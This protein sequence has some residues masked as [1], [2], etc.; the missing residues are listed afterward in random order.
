MPRAQ[1]RCTT[2]RCKMYS[3]R[4]VRECLRHVN[5]L[6]DSGMPSRRRART[7]SHF[8]RGALATARAQGLPNDLDMRAREARV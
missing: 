7:L 2:M 6:K 5:L 4:S 8:T 3:G 1:A